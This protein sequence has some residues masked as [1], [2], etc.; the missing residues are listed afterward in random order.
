MEAQL[1]SSLE[2]LMN[3]IRCSSGAFMSFSALLIFPSNS[4]LEC[5]LLC[6]F[7]STTHESTLF[8]YII[9]IL[10]ISDKDGCTYMV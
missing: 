7:F 8:L 5:L 3:K 4:A 9:I 2:V 1:L 6:P 10:F